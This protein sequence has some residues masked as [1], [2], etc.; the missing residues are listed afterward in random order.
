[1]VCGPRD[2]ESVVSIGARPSGPPLTGGHRNLYTRTSVHAPVLLTFTVSLWVSA[3][4]ASTL[5]MRRP[6][7]Q[8]VRSLAHEVLQDG[9]GI[10]T[11]KAT[12]SGLW[13]EEFPKLCSAGIWEELVHF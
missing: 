2:N 7:H 13:A 9:F 8:A 3:V 4:M 11:R 5:Q 1:M 12:R 10:L 6:R